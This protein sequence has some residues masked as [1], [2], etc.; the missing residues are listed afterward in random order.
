MPFAVA[1]SLWSVYFRV[2]VLGV[3]LIATAQE[4]GYFG[5]S[6]RIVEVRRVIF[7]YF[8]QKRPMI[9]RHEKRDVA[10]LALEEIGWR[11]VL[12]LA[13]GALH[14]TSFR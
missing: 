7:P 6:F 3:S 13:A 12:V 9:L 5:A 1:I 11:I 2:A 10:V 8:E 14:H 4:L